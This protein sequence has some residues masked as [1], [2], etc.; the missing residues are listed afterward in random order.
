MENNLA[1][2][3]KHIKGWG[4]DADPDNEPTYPMKKWTG[5]DHNRLNYDRPEQQP[6]NIEILHSNE[7]PTVSSVFGTSS[8]PSGISGAIRR[9]AFKYSENSFAH[10][11]P[12]VLA[13]R[14]NVWEC[15][16]TD[17]AHGHIPNIIK[18][19]GWKAQWEHNPKAVV[20]KAV[21]VAGVVAGIYMLL[22]RKEK[23][24]KKAYQ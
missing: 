5:D 7:R 18:E 23:A 10:W 24:P 11:M 12:L 6:V 16:L 2:N 15:L 21:I 8:P 3:Y 9:F 4:I 17:I 1:D 13:D 20:K 22:T 14:I 19:G